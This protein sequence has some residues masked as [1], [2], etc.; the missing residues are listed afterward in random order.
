MVRREVG[1]PLQE[2]DGNGSRTRSVQARSKHQLPNWTNDECTASGHTSSS[3][4]T[5]A[6]ELLTVPW[7]ACRG[8][9]VPAPPMRGQW[10]IGPRTYA[11]SRPRPGRSGLALLGR[12][13]CLAPWPKAVSDNPASPVQKLTKQARPAPHFMKGE[14]HLLAAS[15]AVGAPS[16]SPPAL[17]TT[18]D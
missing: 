3:P 18:P 12:E 17:K 9:H 13:T 16:V 1:A 10:G 7:W 15:S 4:R 11:V 2:Q 14:Q 6:R 8:G 5:H